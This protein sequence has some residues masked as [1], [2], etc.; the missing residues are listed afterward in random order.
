MVQAANLVNIPFYF[1]HPQYKEFE[2]KVFTSRWIILC[3]PWSLIGQKLSDRL[4]VNSCH[5]V[6]NLTTIT[7]NDYKGLI[8]TLTHNFFE[9]IMSQIFCNVG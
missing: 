7:M 5:I 1:P 6:K 3:L 2:R 8:F 9:A 4:L